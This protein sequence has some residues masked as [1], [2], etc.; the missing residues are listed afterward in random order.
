[1]SHHNIQNMIEILLMS[2]ALGMDA[3]SLS[4]GIGLQGISRKQ[5][6]KLCLAIGTFHIILTLFGLGFGSLI[7][8][9]LGQMA[10]WFSSFL[11][12]GLGLHMLYHTLFGDEEQPRVL[13]TAIAMIIFS[14]SVSIDALSV[15]F[16]IGLRSTTY[17]VISALSFGGIS[18][19]MCGIGLIIGKKF[20]RSI[21]KYGEVI[22]AIVLICCGVRFILV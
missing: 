14:A 2:F 20:S 4:V 10:V 15:G 11:L 16:S 7:G 18:M 19:L 21:G 5:A 22:G 6:V 8:Y 17:G 3:L 9:Y 13:D 12:V 1:M